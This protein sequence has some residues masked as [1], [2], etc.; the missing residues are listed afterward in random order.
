MDTTQN[1]YC[2]QVRS[3]PDIEDDIQFLLWEEILTGW[4]EQD[5]QDESRDYIVYFDSEENAYALRD[6][7]LALFPDAKC[8]ILSRTREDWTTEWRKYFQPQQVGEYFFIIP[9]WEQDSQLLEENRDLYPIYIFPSMAFGTGNHP[10]TNLCLE[11]LGRLKK[12]AEITEQSEF[13]DVGT[14]SGI[15]GIACA[16]LGMRGLGFDCDPAALGNARYNIE[17]NKV[18]DQFSVFAGTP[19]NIKNG[20]GFDLLLVNLYYRPL[21]W[22]VSTF[23]D[24]ANP[25]AC[26]ILSGI[27]NSQEEQVARTYHNQGLQETQFIRQNGWSAIVGKKR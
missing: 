15:L 4:E 10:T 13:L 20:A 24:L 17:L 12:Q 23:L 18:E 2:L 6:K 5:H 27:L 7:V 21:L 22:M 9:E 8:D 16:K 19:D 3:T 11:S 26:M 1:I 14:G 25:G